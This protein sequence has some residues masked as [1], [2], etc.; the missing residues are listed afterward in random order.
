MQYV[1]PETTRFDGELRDVRSERRVYQREL[2]VDRLQLAEC[3]RPR[4]TE[5]IVVNR[6]A[7]PRKTRDRNLALIIIIIIVNILYSRLP[8]KMRTIYLPKGCELK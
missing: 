6:D 7:A 3:E 1:R 8:H 5:A 4:P 2:V